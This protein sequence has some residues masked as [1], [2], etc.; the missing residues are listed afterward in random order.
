MHLAREFVAVFDLSGVSHQAK[1]GNPCAHL[2]SS[3][4]VRHSGHVGFRGARTGGDRGE[5]VVRCRGWL[6]D[7]SRKKLSM[8]LRLSQSLGRSAVAVNSKQPHLFCL[9]VKHYKSSIEAVLNNAELTAAEKD[10]VT[11]SNS[12]SAP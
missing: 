1:G 12:I 6:R 10:I 2:S 8:W 7:E 4:I 5:L 9:H 11:P 3:F